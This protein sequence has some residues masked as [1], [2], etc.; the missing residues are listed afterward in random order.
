[1]LSFAELVVAVFRIQFNF[2]VSFSGHFNAVCIAFRTV[3]ACRQIAQ[4]VSIAYFC[5]IYI[6]GSSC[7]YSCSSGIDKQA[8]QSGT[9]YRIYAGIVGDVSFSAV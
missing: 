8:S 7:V 1:M 4:A 3:F 6:L 5:D 9:T 2:E